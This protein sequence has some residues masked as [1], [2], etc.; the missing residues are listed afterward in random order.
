M[1]P[2]EQL[3]AYAQVIGCEIVTLRQAVPSTGEPAML[4]FHNP[5]QFKREA[6]ELRKCL[7]NDRKSLGCLG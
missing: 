5:P 7:R 2:L 3:A 6:E 4:T 1:T